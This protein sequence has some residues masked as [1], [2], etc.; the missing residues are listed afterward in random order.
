M[1][2][3]LKGNSMLI[4]ENEIKKI[5]ECEEQLKLIKECL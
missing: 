4:L 3:N 1:T 5:E 2:K